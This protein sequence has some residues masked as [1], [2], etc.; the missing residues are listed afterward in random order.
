VR[1]AVALHVL[2]NGWAVVH[3]TPSTIPRIAS[4]IGLAG[5]AL[6]AAVHFSPRRLTEAKT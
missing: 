4:A 1:A 3:A 5:F 2:W 6:L